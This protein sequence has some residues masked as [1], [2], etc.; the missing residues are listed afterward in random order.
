[1]TTRVA[2]LE[3]FGLE[4]ESFQRFKNKFPENSSI[5]RSTRINMNT[6]NEELKTDQHHVPKN[7]HLLF[8]E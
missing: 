1:M 2:S 6:G 7:V 4:A 8:F 5:S 3:I